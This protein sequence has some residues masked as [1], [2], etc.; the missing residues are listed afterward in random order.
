MQAPVDM[1]AETMG[2][3]SPQPPRRDRERAPLF[4]PRLL[5]FSRDTAAV[6][7]PHPNTLTVGFIAPLCLSQDNVRSGLAAPLIEDGHTTAASV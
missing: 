3:F 6:N 4:H 5:F 7:A 1:A 2:A